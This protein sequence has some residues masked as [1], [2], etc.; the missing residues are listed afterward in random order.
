MRGDQRQLREEV[1][2]ECQ[3][4]LLALRRRRW[5]IR[6]GAASTARRI[7]IASMQRMASKPNND[8][9]ATLVICE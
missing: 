2:L 6:A 3:D 4:E 8:L 1:L 9:T 7:L 5:R